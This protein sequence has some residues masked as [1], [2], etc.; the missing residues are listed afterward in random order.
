MSG[1]DGPAD[2]RGRG[3]RGVP[4]GHERSD[5]YHSHRFAVAVDGL[6]D[7]GVTE[8]RGLEATVEDRT[9]PST[10][11]ADRPWWNPGG[12]LDG[13]VDRPSRERETRSPNLELWRGVTD[14]PALWHWL[15]EW[16]EGRIEPRTV[17]V[18]LL[19][20]T[21]AAAVGWVCPG[22]TPVEWTGPKLAADAP[23]VATERLELAHD[24]IRVATDR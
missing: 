9:G 1:A 14:E 20:E 5:P 17:R 19:D 8:V 12:I 4:D 21:G 23:G 6:P 2:P 22:A 13:V 18:S 7:L 11:D 15:A 10:G 24:G 3:E 16:V